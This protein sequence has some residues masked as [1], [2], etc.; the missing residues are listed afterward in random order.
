M[1]SDRIMRGVLAQFACSRS[2]PSQLTRHELGAPPGQ[3]C[4]VKLV[5]P[6][7]RR[8]IASSQIAANRVAYRHELGRKSTGGP[9]ASAAQPGSRAILARKV[10]KRLRQRERT[11]AASVQCK[12][13][14]VR[15]L[16]YL[17]AAVL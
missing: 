6:T 9:R 13:R 14:K 1:V 16:V 5:T 7:D 4:S 2:R 17:T 15:P 3:D 11:V 8:A 12:A 10:G